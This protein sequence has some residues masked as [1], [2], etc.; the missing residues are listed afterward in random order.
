[1]RVLMSDTAKNIVDQLA[2]RSSRGVNASNY[3]RYDFEPSGNINSIEAF[4]EN[5]LNLRLGAEIK[6]QGK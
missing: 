6:P 2:N 1:M 4:N 5:L 3:L